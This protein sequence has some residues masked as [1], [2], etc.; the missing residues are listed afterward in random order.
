MSFVEQL[1]ITKEK[2]NEIL[3]ALMKAPSV[4][5][6]V[7]CVDVMPLQEGGHLTPCCP[8]L[9]PQQKKLGKKKKIPPNFLSKRDGCSSKVNLT[10]KP[11]RPLTTVKKDVLSRNKSEKHV[12]E[13]EHSTFH[14]KITHWIS[15]KTYWKLSIS[16][17]C[18]TKGKSSLALESI[19]TSF[20]LFSLLSF[21]FLVNEEI[22]YR[23]TICFRIQ[24]SLHRQ[25]TSPNAQWDPIWSR[26]CNVAASMSRSTTESC[27]T[28]SLNPTLTSE[29]YPGR[30]RFQMIF[31]E[32]G[33]PTKIT[34]WPTRTRTHSMVILW[35][36]NAVCLLDLQ[37]SCKTRIFTSRQ[38]EKNTIFQFQLARLPML[39]IRYC[40]EA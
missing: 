10:L 32:L 2:L 23:T 26:D 5:L 19:S 28:L 14:R 34:R 18:T 24:R 39:I 11:R 36:K 33:Q 38:S 6:I 22:Y 4:L 13:R 8:Q 21:F 37:K 30:D 1:K 29:N 16:Q 7:I 35:L 25:H 40:Y 3:S 12:R 9:V 31:F 17:Q 27:R 20:Y 15:F